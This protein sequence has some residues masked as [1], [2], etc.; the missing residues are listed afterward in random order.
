MSWHVLGLR[1]RHP[2]GLRLRR[3]PSGI[4]PRLPRLSRTIET[5]EDWRRLEVR[6]LHLRRLRRGSLMLPAMNRI[7]ERWRRRLTS[8]WW[9]APAHARIRQRLL[10]EQWRCGGRGKLTLCTW[11]LGIEHR[12]L[13]GQTKETSDP[14]ERVD[15]ALLPRSI[16]HWGSTRTRASNAALTL[17]RRLIGVGYGVVL[18]DRATTRDAN[19]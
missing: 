17:A 9:D 4:C 7:V 16:R 13:G 19:Q 12:S 3:V 5:P 18:K 11:E 2:L 8:D 14:A 15:C 1:W 6:R 10:L